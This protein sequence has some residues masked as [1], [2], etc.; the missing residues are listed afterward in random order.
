M[1]APARLDPEEV[2]DGRVAVAV[3]TPRLVQ[4][5]ELVEQLEPDL[6]P[7]S[8]ELV[9]VDLFDALPH[10]P[11]SHRVHVPTND[12]RTQPEGLEHRRAAAHERVGDDRVDIVRLPELLTHLPVPELAQQQ[13]PEKGAGT[14]GEPLVDADDGPV[15]LLNLLLTQRQAGGERRIEPG[16]EREGLP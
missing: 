12:T 11:V 9:E 3:F 13:V 1:W 15:A 5:T 8:R 10:Q 2:L 4:L 7:D 16:F 6:L 14:S